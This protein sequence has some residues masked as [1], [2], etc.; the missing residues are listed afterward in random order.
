[1]IGGNGHLLAV[2]YINACTGT[3]AGLSPSEGGGGGEIDSYKLQVL[4][5]IV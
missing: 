1:M 3:G 2:K 4:D 5:S